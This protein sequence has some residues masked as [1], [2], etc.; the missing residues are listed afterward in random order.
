MKYLLLIIWMLCFPVVNAFTN[1]LAFKSNIKIA[2]VS[3]IINLI[4][5]LF[6][7]YILYK[8]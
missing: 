2:P 3:H 1:Y 6:V 4:I 5:W 8:G 7:G